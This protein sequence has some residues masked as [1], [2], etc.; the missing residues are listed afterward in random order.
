[1]NA[2]ELIDA[3]KRRYDYKYGVR[4]PSQ[5]W[6]RHPGRSYDDADRD[7]A[8]KIADALTDTT[9]FTDAV[10]GAA[11]FHRLGREVTWRR[12]VGEHR[13]TIV[14]AERGPFVTVNGLLQLG[15]VDVGDLNG[16]V[17]RLTKG[18]LR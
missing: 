10:V 3:C 16:L 4:K 13:V 9:P 12:E 17:F 8:V 2:D 7:D 18:D 11:G 15:I 5:I 6:P 1:M 14:L